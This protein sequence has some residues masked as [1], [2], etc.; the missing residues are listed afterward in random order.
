MVE[1]R[2]QKINIHHFRSIR[3][4]E[5]SC[6]PLQLLLGPNNHGKSNILAAIEF[7]LSTTARLTVEDFFLFRNHDER[8]LWV[9]IE[10][11]GLTEQEHKTFQKYVGKQGVV[12]VRKCA[13]LREDQTVESSYHGYVSE[14][15]Q[16][17]LR[18][19]A[20]ERLATREDVER[21]AVQ[22]PELGPLLAE[23]GKITSQ[24]LKHF[25]SNF[26]Q[27]NNGVVP[28]RV[29]LEDG[30]FLGSKNVGGGILPDFYMVPAVRDLSDEVKVKATT[31]FGRLLQRAIQE[32]AT[33]D[34][35]FGEIRQ[36]LDAL[37][38]ALNIRDAEGKRQDQISKLEDM[39]A[40]ELRPWGAQVS[41]E[42]TPPDIE[43]VFELGTR[44]HVDDGLKTIAERKGHGLQRAIMFALLRAWA[45][46][47]H[48]VG[49]ADSSP[50]ARKASDSIIFAIEEPELFLHPQAQRK[51]AAALQAIASTP[52]HQIFVCTHS[53][54]FVDLNHHKS[55]A[56]VSKRDCRQG[57]T[58][59]QCRGE[60]FSGEDAQD[61]KQRFQIA[62]WINPDRA[63]LFFAKKVVLAEG[64]T[65]S[66]TFPFLA[67]LL[68]CI[69]P[70]VTIVNCG[71]KHNLPLYVCLLKAFQIPYV[72]VHDED[73]LP[74]PIP[75]D[76]NADKTREKQR[77]FLLNQTLSELVEAPLGIVQVFRPDF[78]RVA[79]ISSTAG[80]KKGKPLAAVD[81]FARLKAEQV[82]IQIREA[83]STAYGEPQQ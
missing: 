34:P 28:F 67:S 4:L 63:E 38:R 3:D 52:E 20:L 31:T 17:W 68:G 18:A 66:I 2:L 54:Q 27:E 64:D 82:P 47:L 55:I 22:V 14:P 51:L 56:I 72:V 73:P 69:D 24:K 35:R 19:S 33:R 78:E 32:M 30:P 45:S 50:V 83:I 49:N 44:L 12:T 75:A 81:H 65:E 60:L 62:A 40:Q 5:L 10:F 36:Q 42:V 25:Q 57:S 7:A 39:V 11:T 8:E 21:E 71:S 43:Q 23:K 16:W 26:M 77:T 80:E 59:R 41:I 9:E 6:Q 29:E 76:W 79:G 46:V 61:R 37:V 58:I 53:P 70:E 15:E 48:D 1:M 13:R 74:D